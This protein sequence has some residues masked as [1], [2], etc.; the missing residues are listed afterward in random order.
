MN[1][2]SP[3]GN[4]SSKCGLIEQYGRN[5]YVNTYSAKIVFPRPFSD[6]DYMIFSNTVLS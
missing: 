4:K 5:D 2:F 3:D 6:L 1:I